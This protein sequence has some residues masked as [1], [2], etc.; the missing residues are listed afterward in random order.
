[1][2]GCCQHSVS[3]LG[4]QATN[5]SF[6]NMAG[7]TINNLIKEETVASQHSP[8]DS[9]LFDKLQHTASISFVQF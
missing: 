2:H 5:Q 1:M 6:N 7:I 4:L 9:T 3:T 8:L